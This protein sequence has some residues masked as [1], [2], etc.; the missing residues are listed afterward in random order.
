MSQPV[1][2]TN[3][4]YAPRTL[5][6]CTHC[7]SPLHGPPR[8]VTC[9]TRSRF[10]LLNW[11]FLAESVGSGSCF[12]PGLHFPLFIVR[13]LQT[14]LGACT[15][16]ARR[17]AGACLGVVTNPV[18]SAFAVVKGVWEAHLPTISTQNRK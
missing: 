9:S 18:V 16:G 3:D 7:F 8:W 17:L 11:T 1:I 10:R 15:C 5:P 2:T 12:K 14:K 6:H 4:R 13:L